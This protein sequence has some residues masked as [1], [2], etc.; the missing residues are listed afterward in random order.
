[1]LSKLIV[2]ACAALAETK[3]EARVMLVASKLEPSKREVKVVISF[4]LLVGLENVLDC[5]RMVEESAPASY[6]LRY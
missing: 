5:F 1:M 3:E 2:K 6:L 4:A